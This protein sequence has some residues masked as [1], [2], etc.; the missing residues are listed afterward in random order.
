MK[1]YCIWD[2]LEVSNPGK[3]EE[4]KVRVAPIVERYGGKY[5]VVGGTHKVVEG[6]WPLIYPVMIEF[7]SLDKALEWYNSEEYAELKALRQ[8]ASSANAVFIEGL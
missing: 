6:E 4:Y 8:S 3:L 7:P 5:L 2:N 1:A